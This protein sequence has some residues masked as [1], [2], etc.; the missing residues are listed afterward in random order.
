M[1]PAILLGRLGN[2]QACLSWK[3]HTLVFSTDG[4]W[5]REGL[6]GTPIHCGLPLSL[7]NAGTSDKNRSSLSRLFLDGNQAGIRLDQQIDFES[8]RSAPK[9]DLRLDPTVEQ[10]FKN[11]RDNGRFED[12]ASHRP[13]GDM[14]G[15]LP[16]CEMAECSRIGKI[17]FRRFDKSLADLAKCS[18]IPFQIRLHVSSVERSASILPLCIANAQLQDRL[19]RKT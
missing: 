2:H 4:N 17:D 11:F 16:P 15:G 19:A 10:R 14:F 8:R 3:T 13:L 5:I 9:V 7:S 1:T 18:Y 12:R 6:T